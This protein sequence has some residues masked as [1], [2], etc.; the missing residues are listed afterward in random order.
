MNDFDIIIIGAGASGLMAARKLSE[1]GKKT[2]V[3]EARE[4]LG[5]RI[6]T[7]TE[8][9]F[10]SYIEAGAEFVHGKLPLTEAVLKEAE[11][12]TYNMEGETYQVKH[13]AIVEQDSFI[14]DFSVL[15]S[16]IKELKEDMPFALFLEKHLKEDKYKSLR[17]SAR[18]Y[19]EGYDASD[20][21]KVSSFALREEWMSEASSMSY[22]LKGG[23]G[24]M[25]SFLA[26]RSIRSG[27]IIYHSTIVK[28]IRWQEGNVEVM[29]SEDKIFNAKKVI[30]TIPLGVLQ[31]KPGSP[32]SITFTPEI[33]DTYNSLQH[34]GYGSV[35]KIFLEF[36]DPFWEGRTSFKGKVR[37]MPELDFVLSDALIPTWWTQM[38]GNR[39]LLTGWL[40][41]PVAKKFQDESEE[42]LILK[43]LES[44]SYI[45]G[46]KQP[47]LLDHLIAKKVVNWATDPFALGAYSYATVESKQALKKLTKP[48]KNTIYFAGE[49]FYEGAAMGTVEAALSSALNVVKEI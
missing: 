36:K 18:M 49:A 22:R 1:A 10:S 9:G 2:L 39:N 21:K 17:E 27:A 42:A 19:A 47:F 40:A 45:F 23:Y 7:L 41:G 35:I 20:I 12:G 38:Q 14:D 25:I 37:K 29:C 33:S 30:I 15:L 43:S 4:R 13:G 3:L 31:L 24:K 8:E 44:L 5:G 48:I 11:I 28:E 34:L 26:N 6:N 46:T 32:G 16:K